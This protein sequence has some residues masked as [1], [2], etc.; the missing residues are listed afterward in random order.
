MKSPKIDQ[1][2]LAVLNKYSGNEQDPNTPDPTPAKTDNSLSI[3]DQEIDNT[4]NRELKKKYANAILVIVW[5]WIS[6]IIALLVVTG[7]TNLCCEKQ[8]LSDAVLIALLSS[9]SLVSLTAIILHHL[10]PRK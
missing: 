6:L 2:L 10:F 7:I 5:I 3:R 4:L 1:E 9:T 8:F